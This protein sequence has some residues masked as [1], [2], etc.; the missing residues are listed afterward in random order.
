MDGHRI[1]PPREELSDERLREIVVAEVLMD[2]EERQ[3]VQ[4]TWA[5]PRGTTRG[6][7]ATAL[8]LAAIAGWLWIFP[9]AFLAPPP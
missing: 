4:R 2:A 8:V 1:P 7:I 6:R 3:I 5:P 9:P